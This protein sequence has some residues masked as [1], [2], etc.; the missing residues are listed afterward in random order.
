MSRLDYTLFASTQNNPGGPVVQY[1]DDEPAT[2]EPSLDAAGNS[3]RA[4]LIAYGIAYAIA[5]A[6][7]AYFLLI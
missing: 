2:I 4:G 3:T 1:L 7:T 5:F 6:A